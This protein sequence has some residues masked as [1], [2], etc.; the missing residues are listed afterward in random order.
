M[1]LS[2]PL[3]LRRQIEHLVT[4]AI[5][6]DHI[7]N[8]GVTASNRHSPRHLETSRLQK[9]KYY[10]TLHTLTGNISE[11]KTHNIGLQLNEKVNR[12][13][14]RARIA[15]AWYVLRIAWQRIIGCL[16]QK[17]SYYYAKSQFDLSCFDPD[18]G[19]PWL[20]KKCV[21]IMTVPQLMS[22]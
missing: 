20:D 6:K 4:V 15:I 9:L 2:F 17:Q 13:T 19:W 8:Q 7:A 21:P 10:A 11:F 12:S 1:R 22:W 16:C 3:F 5:E 14:M 18:T